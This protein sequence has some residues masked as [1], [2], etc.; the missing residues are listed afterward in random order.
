[1]RGF[2]FFPSTFEESF[3]INRT[4]LVVLSGGQ[5]STTCLVWALMNYARVQAITFN[6]GQRHNIELQA[7][8]DV[9]NLAGEIAEARGKPWAAWRAGELMHEIVDVGPILAGRSPLTDPSA[10]LERYGSFDEM[11]KVIGDRVELTFVPM[12]NALFLTLAANRA[13]LIDGGV[14]IVTGVCEADNANYPD[15]RGPFIDAQRL[16][17]NTA[18]GAD[19]REDVMPV[20]ILTPLIGATKAESIFMLAG[21]GMDALCLL[22]FSHTAYD[23][24]Y[25]PGNDHASV[26]RA[27]GFEQAC[28]PD[29]LIVR[30]VIE[31][32]IQHFPDAPNYKDEETLKSMIKHIT[33]L[34]DAL[35]LLKGERL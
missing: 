33:R 4:A 23:G 29:P 14:D 17:I 11:D 3:M 9:V 1:M 22:A 30:A 12:R 19:T 10:T 20:N 8:Q 24:A 34:S 15:C 21:Y 6:Y 5:D 35:R 16:A 18:L 32:H 27:H 2:F 7:A 31:G 28:V 25:P 26:L 13:A